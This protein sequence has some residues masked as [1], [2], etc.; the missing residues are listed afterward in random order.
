[1]SETESERNI[2]SLLSE[3]VVGQPAALQYIVPYI[4]MFRAGLAPEGR[5][6]GVFLLLGP[7]G[8]GKTKTVEA[9]ADILH[10]SEKS[11]LRIDCGEFQTEHEVAKLI[12]APPGYV[13]HRETNPII[14]DKKLAEVVSDDCD[15]AIILFDE[16]EKAAPSLTRLLLGILDKATLR[17][18]DNT[19]VN[20]E[21]TIV[22]LTSNLGARE[23]MRELKPDFGFQAGSENPIPPDLGRKLESVALAAVRR[24]F[25]PEFVNR[26]D[27]V[28]TYQPLDDG[29]LSAILDREV[30][31]LQRHVNTRLAERCFSIEVSSESRQFLLRKGTSREF[32]ARELK[33]TIHR[34]VTQPLATLVAGGQIEPG[35]T[36]RV[37]ISA[38]GE[39]LVIGT[40]GI[41]REI[42]DCP[43]VLLV[44]DNRDLLRLFER[45]LAATKWNVMTAENGSQCHDMLQQGPNV[46]VLDYLLPDANGVD[47]A[48][49][50]R[51][52]HHDAAIIIATGAELSL[53]D[54][55]RCSS[56]EFPVLRK[57]FLADELTKLIRACLSSGAKPKE[58]VAGA[59]AN[60]ARTRGRAG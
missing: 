19:T 39:S 60:A 11:L 33:R 50:I 23:I 36:V 1:M 26:L 31:E 8:T 35:S 27:A 49:H 58:A 22:F 12:G 28:I 57:P 15:L 16:I 13:G 5:P 30:H 14:T 55:A 21:R 4:D 18:G 34:N 6:A 17:L 25:S 7:T 20:F 32:G 43:K 53:E 29:A 37:D 3:K 42:P 46:I 54:Q 10:G 45:Q 44:D 59:T 38:D 47:L 9:V 24:K 48:C 41:Q 52:I 56:N 2:I 51:S 40:R